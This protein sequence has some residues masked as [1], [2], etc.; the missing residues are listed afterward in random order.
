MLVQGARLLRHFQTQN[1]FRSSSNTNKD[2]VECYKNV[3][4]LIVRP[5]R[6]FSAEGGS[7][8]QNITMTTAPTEANW[9][10][11]LGV[12]QS[13]VHL[14]YTKPSKQVQHGQARNH[15]GTG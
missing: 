13:V 6:V 11:F 7:Q 14:Q 15:D 10:F 1:R 3:R 5:S 9:G 4:V 12:S 2:L 8:K